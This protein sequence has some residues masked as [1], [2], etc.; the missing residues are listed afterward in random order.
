M[1]ETRSA[2]RTT[3]HPDEKRD[4]HRHAD[5]DEGPSIGGKGLSA[6]L[7]TVLKHSYAFEISVQGRDLMI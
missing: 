3:K 6:F 5:P 4:G 1:R 7:P 2:T